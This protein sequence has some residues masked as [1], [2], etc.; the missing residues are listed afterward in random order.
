[1]GI[2]ISF[3]EMLR[4]EKG[5]KRK[6]KKKKEE[7]ERKKRKRKKTKVHKK[8]L[9]MKRVRKKGEGLRVSA[10]KAA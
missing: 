9:S 8:L 4:G 6:R 3:S 5:G 10:S 2:G 7:R 1:L